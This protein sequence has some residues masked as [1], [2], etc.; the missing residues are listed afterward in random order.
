[1]VMKMSHLREVPGAVLGDGDDDEER[2]QRHAHQ[3]DHVARHW[4]NKFNG[5]K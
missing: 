5:Y 1:M 2:H 3:Q 4:N